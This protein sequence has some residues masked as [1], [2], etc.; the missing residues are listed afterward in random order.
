MEI[1]ISENE[2]HLD[3]FNIISKEEVDNN[4]LLYNVEPTYTVISC[5]YCNGNVVKTE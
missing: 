2:L 4:T 1:I 5:P 3:E